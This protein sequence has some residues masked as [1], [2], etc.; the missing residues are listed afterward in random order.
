MDTDSPP[1]AVAPPPPAPPLARQ[2][3]VTP[4]QHPSRQ[5]VVVKPPAPSP[6]VHDQPPLPRTRPRPPRRNNRS[7]GKGRG[8]GT[9]GGHSGTCTSTK[10]EG[11]D[12]KVGHRRRNRRS[13]W[14]R[15]NQGG[16]AIVSELVL[17]VII[18][19]NNYCH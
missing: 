15:E 2:E 10:V 18:D 19:N 13:A 8:G 9:R 3:H 4:P 14:Y 5:E 12:V 7:R 6:L 1:P 11:G 17:Y 16:C